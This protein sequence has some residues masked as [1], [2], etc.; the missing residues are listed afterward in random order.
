MRR[1]NGD[2]VELVGARR[3]RGRSRP[4]APRLPGLGTALAPSDPDPNGCGFPGRCTRPA[5]LRRLRQAAGDRR[6]RL[7]PSASPTCSPCS[8]TR[9]SRRPTSSATTGARRSRGRWRCWR[10]S[11]STGSSRSRSGIPTAFAARGIEQRRLSWYMLLFQFEE[12]EELLRQDDWALM[13]EWAASHPDLD[14]AIADLA[15][16]GALTA[17]LNWYRASLHPRADLEPR[18]RCR[19]CRPT[20]SASS[21]PA[22]PSWSRTQMSESGHLRRRRVA[23]RAHRGRRAL[24][25]C[26]S[27]PSASTRCCLTS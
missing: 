17:A 4:P 25:A 16:P 13:R 22:T 27:S 9:A 3:G 6:L 7:R 24:D 20:R 2:G 19:R 12:A 11:A 21:A 10:P 8:T 14:Q 5:R 23:L 1:I 26:S 15:R 18:G